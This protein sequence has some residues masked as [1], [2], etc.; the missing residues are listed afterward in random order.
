MK[1]YPTSGDSNSRRTDRELPVASS[2]IS[3]RSSGVTGARDSRECKEDLFE[4]AAYRQSGRN[5]QLGQR[6]DTLY[7]A[8]AQ[9]DEPIAYALGIGADVSR[10]PE[11]AH[12]PPRSAVS[13]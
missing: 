3:L 8:G 7:E 4:I 13:S 10:A 12:P 6:A 2:R 5:G 11:C 9:E 1:L